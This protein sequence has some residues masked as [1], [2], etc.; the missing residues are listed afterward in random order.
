MSLDIKVTK[1]MDYVYMVEL[2]GSLDVETHQLLD[3]ELKELI[4]DKTKAVILD[5]ASLEYISSIGIRTV[6]WAKKAL[7]E[8]DASFSMINFQPQIKKVF[9]AMKILPMFNIF[10]NMPEAD[11]YIDQ[12]IKDE[13][14]KTAQ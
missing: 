2:A 12:M 14:R 7:K 8:K 4:D 5:M 3:A 11:M 13:M 9:E 1:K 10:D 6:I